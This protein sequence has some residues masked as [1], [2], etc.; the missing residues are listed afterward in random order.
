MKKQKHYFYVYNLVAE[1]GESTHGFFATFPK[2][3]SAQARWNR[4]RAAIGKPGFVI[5]KHLVF[6]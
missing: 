4:M 2:A 6:R 3:R 5:A 1:T